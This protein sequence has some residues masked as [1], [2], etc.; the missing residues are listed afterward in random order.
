M[1]VE[2]K[3]N[4]NAIREKLYEM[5][6]LYAD[7]VDFILCHYYKKAFNFRDYEFLNGR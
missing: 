2:F 6:I 1:H 4:E 7:F 5:G 3:S